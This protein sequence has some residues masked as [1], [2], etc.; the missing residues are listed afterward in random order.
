MIREIYSH[1]V[2]KLQKTTNGVLHAINKKL[3]QIAN[4]LFSFELPLGK[5]C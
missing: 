3:E 4:E 2:E 5:Y 1:K